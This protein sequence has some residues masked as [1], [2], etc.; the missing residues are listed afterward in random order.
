MVRTCIDVNDTG[1]HA[2]VAQVGGNARLVG[3]KEQDGKARV[4]QEYTTR[5]LDH[6]RNFGAA[7]VWR[8]RSVLFGCVEGCC[9]IWDRST[10]AVIC[11]LDHGEGRKPPFPALF[12]TLTRTG[13]MRSCRPWR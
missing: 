6:Q 7:F 8:G 5:G 4:E 2:L 13:Q 11:A 3:I 1:Q 12:I 10:G 9:L